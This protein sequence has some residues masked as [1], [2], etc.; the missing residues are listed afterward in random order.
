MTNREFY[1]LVITL[2]NEDAK[3]FAENE[4]Q[5]MDARN[6]KR[7]EM[8]KKDSKAAVA[9]RELI[10]KALEF[11]GKEPMTASAI[12]EKLEISAQKASAIMKQGVKEEKV[13]VTD[14]KVKGRTVKGYFIG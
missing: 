14:L 11:I 6:A 9:N 2:G 5:K 4:L 7:R 3:I 13:K 10:A 1:Q 12:G 8:P